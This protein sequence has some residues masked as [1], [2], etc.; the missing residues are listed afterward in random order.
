MF[1]LINILLI[2]FFLKNLSCSVRIGKRP[3]IGDLSDSGALLLY[4]LYF[5]LHILYIKSSILFT[6]IIYDCLH[7]ESV[8]GKTLHVC[9]L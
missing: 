6:Y 9:S 5:I 8:P 3:V 4:F 1:S 2:Y 7:G